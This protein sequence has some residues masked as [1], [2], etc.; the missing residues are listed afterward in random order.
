[1]TQY[2]G[3]F[4]IFDFFVQY[5]ELTLVYFGLFGVVKTDLNVAFQF[6]QFAVI[7]HV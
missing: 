6:S 2:I 7:E 1:M 3:D 4:L 5:F